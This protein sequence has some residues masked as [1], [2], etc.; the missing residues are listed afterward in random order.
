MGKN[1]SFLNWNETRSSWQKLLGQKLL[2][3]FQFNALRMAT[4]VLLRTNTSNSFLYWITFHIWKSN[5]GNAKHS[6]CTLLFKPALKI[7][8]AYFFTVFHYK[9]QAGL[10]TGAVLTT[11]LKRTSKSVIRY[12]T[13]SNSFQLPVLSIPCYAIFFLLWIN[14]SLTWLGHLMRIWP[15]SALD[16]LTECWTFESKLHTLLLSQNVPRLSINS[17][18]Q[19]WKHYWQVNWEIWQYSHTLPGTP[20]CVLEAFTALS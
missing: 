16:I 17:K 6:S 3:L 7:C 11:F 8:N 13:S 5:S 4:S 10:D 19:Q 20:V 14:S 1:L 15:N 12:E 2:S 9:S 18:G